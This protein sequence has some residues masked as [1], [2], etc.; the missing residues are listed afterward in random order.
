MHIKCLVKTVT[1]RV[2][3]THILAMVIIFVIMATSRI[4]SSLSTSPSRR[5]KETPRALLIFQ[6]IVKTMPEKLF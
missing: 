6:N 2:V 5:A 3:S 1:W 4:I